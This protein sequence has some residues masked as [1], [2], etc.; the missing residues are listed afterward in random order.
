MVQ[1]QLVSDYDVIW[2]AMAKQKKKKLISHV[3]EILNKLPSD[4]LLNENHVIQETNQLVKQRL[5]MIRFLLT[6][7]PNRIKDVDSM[8]E[9]LKEQI[10]T[11][12]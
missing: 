3:M 10:K 4:L 11:S 1:Q 9:L 8:K 12:D 5:N 2:K 7:F 6:I